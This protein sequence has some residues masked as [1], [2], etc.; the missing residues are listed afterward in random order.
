ME[1]YYVFWIRR[2][3][4][5]KMSILPQVA[6]RVDVIHIKIPNGIFLKNRK[7]NF[8]IHMKPQKTPNSQI[9]LEKEAQ[10]WRHH[11]S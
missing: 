8:K 4:T 9:S 2:L 6:Y 7:N 10:S 11:T 5:V 3:N 1:R